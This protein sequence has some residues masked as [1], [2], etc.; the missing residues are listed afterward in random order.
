MKALSKLKSVR[1]PYKV[2]S[3][4]STISI[5]FAQD[6]A[7]SN[8]FNVD[9]FENAFRWLR[10]INENDGLRRTYCN[11][12]SSSSDHLNPSVSQSKFTITVAD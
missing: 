12:K 3:P 2:E 11:A 1:K 10:L 5:A 4:S 7:L 6:L 8:E 9:Q